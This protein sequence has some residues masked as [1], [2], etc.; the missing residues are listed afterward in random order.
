[1]SRGPHAGFQNVSG[2]RTW[3][4]RSALRLAGKHAERTANVNTADELAVRPAVSALN[5]SD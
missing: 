5:P 2:G 1:V 4:D 3:E